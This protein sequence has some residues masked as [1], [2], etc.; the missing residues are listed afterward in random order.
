MD[1]KAKKRL[2]TLQQKRQKLMGELGVVRRHPDDPAEIPKL[3]A[4][5]AAIEAEIAKLKES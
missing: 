4:E 3:E 5:L 2:T 1:K